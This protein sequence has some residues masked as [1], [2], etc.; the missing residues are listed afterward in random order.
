MTNMIEVK[1]AELTGAALDWA[2]AMAEGFTPDPEH[3]TTVLSP[4]GVA[5]S[6]SPRGAS[7]GFGYRPSA[8]WSQGG[9]LIQ[10]N[11]VD[12]TVEHANVIF[13]CL[14]D[15]NGMWV[16]R[17]GVYGCFGETY[18]IAACRAIALTKLGD[19]VQVPRELLS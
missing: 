12:F 11:L 1:T 17:E 6:V 14:V 18:L 2:V 13:A 15:E 3:R 19:T 8:D 9:P 7:E 5:T 16:L 10:Q 4:Q